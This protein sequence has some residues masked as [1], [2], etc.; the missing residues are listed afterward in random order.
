MEMNPST[1]AKGLSVGATAGCAMN[2]GLKKTLDLAN[3]ALLAPH[4]AMKLALVDIDWNRRICR[5]G[6]A[7]KVKSHRAD[8]QAWP[9][10]T[11]PIQVKNT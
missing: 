11:S 7:P 3:P 9:A 2:I 4:V 10:W 1:S 6:D 5:V 8:A